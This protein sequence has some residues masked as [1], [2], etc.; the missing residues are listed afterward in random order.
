MLISQLGQNLTNF[1]KMTRII[2]WILSKKNK[3]VVRIKETNFRY[4]VR[5]NLS[6]ITLTS[7]LEDKKNG[8]KS[9]TGR[10]QHVQ[11]QRY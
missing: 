9:I 11:K 8:T 1:F 7:Q 6:K 2:N 3:Q 4:Q 10:K 5:K